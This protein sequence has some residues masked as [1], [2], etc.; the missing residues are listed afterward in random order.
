MINGKKC[1]ELVE[2]WSDIVYLIEC[3]LN[4]LIGLCVGE[5]KWNFLHEID[6][7]YFSAAASS[8][9]RIILTFFYKDD[10]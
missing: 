9:K 7:R 3:Q 5:K 1:D 8:F 6:K 4:K 2:K 10:R